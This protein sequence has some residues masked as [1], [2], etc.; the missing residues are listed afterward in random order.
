[1]TPLCRTLTLLAC[2]A[3]GV[4][5]AAQAPTPPA[6]APQ[7]Q[8]IS[9][10]IDLTGP[11]E[12]SAPTAQAPAAAST[13]ALRLTLGHEASFATQE[14]L[15]IVNNR[16][17]FRVEYS[18]LLADR[19]HIQFDSKLNAY[20]GSDHRARAENKST[21]FETSTPEAYVQYSRPGADTSI[22]LGVQRLIWGESEAG[23]ITDEISPRNFS[24]LFFIPLEESRLGQFMAT[25][26]HFSKNGDWTFFYVPV[27]RFNELPDP[28][29]E[30]G[31]DPFEG[32][33]DIEKGD[34]KFHEFGLRWK[35]TV[36]R[37][38]ISFMAAN[39]VDNDY[40]YRL[41]GMTGGRLAVSR[42]EQRFSM[43]GTTFNYAKQN[44][45]FK[46]EVA[47]KSKK[48]FNDASLNVLERNV[49]DS[50]LGL[51][52]ALRT[53]NSIGVE[54]VN[55][56]VS[57]WTDQ[58]VG[59]PRNSTSLVLNANLFFLNDT[60]SVNWLTIYNRPYTSYQSSL[61]TSY[62][63]SDAL[64]LSADVHFI[65]VPD[66]NSGLYRYRDKDQVFVRVQYQF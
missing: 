38:D 5:V 16:S 21:L 60:F 39:L 10:E 23:A 50:S 9:P 58:I 28:G 41:D 56:R 46:G 65:S 27:P 49:L 57:G 25:V 11:S 29:T 44:F 52:Y 66:Q 63:W 59:V 22:K 35:K 45:L 34:R 18:K 14:H 31:F 19:F 55:S 30:Y 24:E 2:L 64:T 53:P 6:P 8:E 37:S 20:W 7:P 36:D 47:F 48:G 13:K 12:P 61:R 62:K 1:M 33:A 43:V 4:P 3:A 40:V 15:D 51:T 26:D 17:W 42:L 32:R 54:L